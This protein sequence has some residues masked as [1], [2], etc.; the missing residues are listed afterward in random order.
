M[1]KRI[2]LSIVVLT[3]LAFQQCSAPAENSATTSNLKKYNEVHLVLYGSN[4]CGH[5]LRFKSELDSV[6]IKYT[7]HDVEQDESLARAMLDAV[8]SIGYYGYIL[9]PVV[10]T[11]D[12]VFI[13][14]GLQ[15]VLDVL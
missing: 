2:P 9:F 14:P 7:F 11:G 5:C 13:K 8:H 6:G 12:T 15:E 3:V 1:I 10:A 4:S